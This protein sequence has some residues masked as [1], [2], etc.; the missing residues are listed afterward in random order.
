M[1]RYTLILD[2]NLQKMTFTAGEIMREKN[3]FKEIFPLA[4]KKKNSAK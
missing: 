1:T 2:T 4:K 3:D